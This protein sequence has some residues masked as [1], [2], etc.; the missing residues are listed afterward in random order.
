[1]LLFSNNRIVN[2]LKI[3]TGCVCVY[4]DLQSCLICI[5][6]RVPRVPPIPVST[7]SFITKQDPTGIFFHSRL[8]RIRCMLCCSTHA[9]LHI[10]HVFLNQSFIK[11]EREGEFQRRYGTRSSRK[12]QYFIC[13]IESRERDRVRMKCME[14]CFKCF[15]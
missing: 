11:R 4:T 6:C 15:I 5:A 14:D 2:I 9:R 10:V 1:M 7:E 13:V 8:W 3:Q 12:D